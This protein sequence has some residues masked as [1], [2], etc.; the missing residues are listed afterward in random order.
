MNVSNW[1]WHYF[2]TISD[3]FFAN[4]IIIFDKTEALFNGHFDIPNMSKSDVTLYH[5]MA[6]LPTVRRFTGLTVW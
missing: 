6:L 4:Y 3:H 5:Y 1:L 2:T